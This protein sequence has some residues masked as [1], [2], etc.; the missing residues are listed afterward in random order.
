MFWATVTNYEYSLLFLLVEFLVNLCHTKVVI[1]NSH[2]V[3]IL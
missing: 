3:A 1:P 2:N